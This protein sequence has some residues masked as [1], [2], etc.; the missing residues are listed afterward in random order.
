MVAVRRASLAAA[1]LLALAFVVTPRIWP[2]GA[3]FSPMS[4][5]WAESADDAIALVRKLQDGQISIVSRAAELNLRERYDGLRPAIGAAFD[6]HGM[7]QTCYGAGWDKLTDAQ[8]E[9]WT[10]AFGDYVA[11]SYAARMEGLNVAG[12]EHEAQTVSRGDNLVVTSRM[13]LTDGPP[14]PID[15]VMRQ[16]PKGWRIGDILANGSISE[17]AQWRRSLRGATGGGDFAAGLTILRQRKDAFL[18]P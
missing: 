16:T 3:G 14:A 17:L 15:Y 4:A 5:A 10:E 13:L 8:R 6:L 7:A 2:L 18:T 11:A 9:E 12:F 1:C